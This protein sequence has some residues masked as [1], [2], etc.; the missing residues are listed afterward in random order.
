MA[1]IMTLDRP[2]TGYIVLAWRTLSPNFTS[3][4][5]ITWGNE[6]YVSEYQE[7]KPMSRLWLGISAM[8][9][10]ATTD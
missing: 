10:I 7:L 5:Q 2:S 1:A 8:P 6:K 3:A 9:P 4:E